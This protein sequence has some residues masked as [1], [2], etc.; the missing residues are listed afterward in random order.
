[1]TNGPPRIFDRHA[2]ALHRARARKIAGD[3]F[4]EQEAAEGLAE[5]L[6]SVRRTFS[7]ALELEPR[8]S[9]ADTFHP[10]AKHWTQAPLQD[11]ESFANGHEEFDLIVSALSLH[12]VNDLPGVLVQV[13]RA[14][15]PDGLF[16][17]ALF[18]G[19]TLF[20]LRD[21]LAA[22][23]IE[24]KGGISPRV[25]PFA[26]VRDLGGLLQRAG[27]SLPV[28]DVE[29]TVVRYRDFTTLIAD[30]RAMG[31]TNALT[32]RNRGPISRP[33]LAAAMAYYA[34]HH[35]DAD[36]RLR[37][38]F[39]IVYLTGWAPHESQQKPLKPGSASS[40]LA[41]ALKTTEHSA[42]EPVPKVRDT[43]PETGRCR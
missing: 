27:F 8:V 11:D 2:L 36:G 33:T 24:T 13:R 34:A 20:E 19:E 35:A 26:D 39:D 42:G 3:A 41:E 22:S 7:N 32:E 10:L 40:R 21:A 12:A 25:A 5:R 31:E 23:E 9:S 29:R 16:M 43:P 14:L 6:S 1:M 37:A 28:A 15:K 30:L 18:G 17:A 38:T 4:L